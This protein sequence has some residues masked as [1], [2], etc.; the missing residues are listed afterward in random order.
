MDLVEAVE[1]SAETAHRN[2]QC[3]RPGIRIFELSSKTGAG[4]SELIQWFVEP[5]PE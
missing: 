5:H 2:I 1:F 4:V 3:V